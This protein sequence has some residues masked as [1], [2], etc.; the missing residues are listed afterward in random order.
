MT[1]ERP[2]LG[3][4]FGAD[5]PW[6]AEIVNVLNDVY[7]LLDARLPQN[8]NSKGPVPISEPAPAGPPA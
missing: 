2:A 7:D 3:T 4:P 5:G 6:L 1:R 8:D